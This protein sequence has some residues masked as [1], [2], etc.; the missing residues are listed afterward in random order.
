MFIR[1]LLFPQAKFAL[2]AAS[3]C[4]SHLEVV[5]QVPITAGWPEAD[6]AKLAKGYSHG[7]FGNRTPN[8]KLSSPTP[9]PTVLPLGHELLLAPCYR[10]YEAHCASVVAHDFIL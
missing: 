8:L 7:Q 2:E 4:Q 5:L 6:N 1:L 9:L 3:N 10:Y